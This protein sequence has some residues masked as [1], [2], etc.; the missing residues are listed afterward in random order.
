MPTMPSG[1]VAT[2]HGDGGS[3][4]IAALADGRGAGSEDMLGL[5]G[6]G[7][8]EA[9]DSVSGRVI[10]LTDER[11]DHILAEHEELAGLKPSLLD[12]L[13]RP[14]RVLEGGAGELL[15][16]AEVEVGKVLVVVYRETE[17]DGFVDHRISDAACGITGKETHRMAALAVD[18]YLPLVAALLDAP[19]GSM[20]SSYDSEADVLYINFK[21]PSIATDS[22][23]RDDDVIVRY[24][25]EDVVGF[26]V[27]HASRRPAS[28]GR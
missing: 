27:L 3:C 23:L 21:R 6:E 11:W 12:V 1:A 5:R 8:A 20:W 15:A 16:V 10:R 2:A 19:N 18:A 14:D 24:D 25:G 4:S 26:T 9:V 13:G 7:M 17:E 28:N 22:E